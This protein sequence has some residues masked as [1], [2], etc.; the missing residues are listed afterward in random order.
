[1]F[2]VPTNGWIW[3]KD[4]DSRDNTEPAIV[5]FRKTLKLDT[6]PTAMPA[7]VSADSRYKLYINGS[8]AEVGPLKGDRQIWYYD[9]VDIAP[10]LLQGDNVISAVVLRYPTLYRQGNHS[11]F[12]TETPGFYLKSALV[13]TDATWRTKKAR[14]IKIVG[15]NLYFAP[16]HISENADGDAE[17][18]RFMDIGFDS[19]AWTEAVEYN[20]FAMPKAVSPGNL[21]ERSIPPLYR[22][23]RFFKEVYCIRHSA[24]A[25]QD[26]EGMLN[27]VSAID[28]PARANETVEISA[29]EETTG[30]LAL[31]LAQGQGASIKILTAECYAYEPVG[32]FMPIPRKG[33]RTDCEGGRLFGFTDAYTPLG[34]GTESEPEV[35]EPFWFRTF[36]FV[37]LEI[38]TGSVPLKILGFNY[39]ETGYPLEIKTEVKTSDETLAAV[40]DISA[41]TLRRCMHETYEDCPFYEQLQYA[42]DSR[43]QI[44]Y[45]YAVSADDRLARKCMDDFRRSQRYDGMINCSY[46]CY[47]SNIIPGFAIYYIGMVYDHMMYFGDE[48][49]VQTHL[50]AIMGVLNY[51]ENNRGTL[52]L[53]GKIGGL[54][55]RD[56]YW[57]FIDWTKEWNET[58]GVPRAALS[59]PITMESLLYVLGLM[60]ASQ[61]AMFAREDQLAEKL[62]SRARAVRDAVNRNCRGKNGLYQDGPGVEEYSQ[63][64]Q[65]FAVLTDT[66]GAAEGGKYLQETLDRPGEYAQCSVAMMYYLYR[67]LEKCG[68]YERTKA[69]WDTWREMVRKNLTTCEEDPVNSRSDCHAWGALALYELPSAVLG[70]R[71]GKPGYAEIIVAPTAGYMTWAE[72]RVI[73]PRGMVEVSWRL[74]EGKRRM[75]VSA[76]KSVK[77]APAEDFEVETEMV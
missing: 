25:K 73:T 69:L 4:W 59:G 68:M 50:P 27:G 63:H 39:T 36:R 3:T 6:V 23:K 15:E 55:M 38:A 44:L 45:T 76:P 60:Y 14:R 20:D 56:R 77:L 62:N 28:I 26:W 24:F 40:W 2:S 65:V 58:T 43:N 51:F 7:M 41:R 54:N 12:R 47:G 13:S 17:T 34:R 11:V 48:A 49:L 32:N 64:C 29:G 1:M 70:V 33:D 71:P 21:I 46:P 18:F 5:Y 9:T 35:Y 22:V 30:Y 52:G 53:V 19:R 10:Y 8:L 74:E 37:R 42:M 57:S 75:K 16:L 31:A 61:L 67:A 66:V 72:G